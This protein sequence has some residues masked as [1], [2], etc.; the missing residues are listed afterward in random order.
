MITARELKRYEIEQIWKIDRREVIEDVYHLEE[1]ALVLKP[2]H[3]DMQGW[4]HGEAESYTPILHEC[5]DRGGWFCGLFDENKIIGAAILDSKFIGKGHDQLQ[6]KFLHISRD[7]RKQGLGKRLFEMASAKASE[8]G[9]RQMYISATP[10]QNT[11]DFYLG[12]G[13]AVTKHPDPDLFALEPEDVH[14][15]CDV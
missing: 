3:Y 8:W 6:L 5:F 12:L 4:P 15:Q 13:A 10:S 7:Y 2:E 14:L 11:V 1:G 9:A